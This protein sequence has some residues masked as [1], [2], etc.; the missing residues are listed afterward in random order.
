MNLPI[1]NI[2]TPPT[3]A[4]P[5]TTEYIEQLN[6]TIQLTTKIATDNIKSQ[7]EKNKQNY[8]RNAAHPKFA[9]GI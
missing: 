6:K 7:Q 2:L 5:A 8:D 1:D 4:N 9:V 3:D